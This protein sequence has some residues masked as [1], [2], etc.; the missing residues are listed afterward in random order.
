MH[1]RGYTLVEMVAVIT[2]LGIVGTVSSYVIFESMRVYARTVPALDATY[3]AHLAAERMKSDL[4]DME[5]GSITTFTPTA[6]TFRLSSGQTIAYTVSGSSLL[7]NG[8]LLAKGAG[9]FGLTY[10]KDDGTSATSAANVH[11]VE[12]DL[13]VQAAGQPY[14]VQSAVFPR[15][16]GT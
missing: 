3:Q 9:A 15:S 2:I 13:T 7:R 8:D 16:L 1:R 5:A 6:L 14:R 10:W 11:L 4:R 12:L